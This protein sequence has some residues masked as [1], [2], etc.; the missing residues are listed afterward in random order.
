ME[1]NEWE[2]TAN[3]LKSTQLELTQQIKATENQLDDQKIALTK[4]QE[5]RENYK[6]RHEERILQKDKIKK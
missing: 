3:D 2:A 4:Y 5:R 1:A 6:K